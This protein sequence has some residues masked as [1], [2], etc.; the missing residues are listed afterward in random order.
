MI[1]VH[2]I[3]AAKVELFHYDTISLAGG[4]FS[5]WRSIPHG[6]NESQP[7]V[8]VGVLPDGVGLATWAE[9]PGE[10]ETAGWA[11]RVRLDVTEPAS[12]P[13]SP[14]HAPEPD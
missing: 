12:S 4:S 3:V 2:G 5:P 11:G 13:V 6:P 10:P 8:E 7:D 9:E 1:Q 14:P